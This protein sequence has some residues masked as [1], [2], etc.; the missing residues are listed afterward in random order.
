MLPRK[1]KA[2][3][4]VRVRD[5]YKHF[6]VSGNYYLRFQTNAKEMKLPIWVDVQNLDAP[7]PSLKSRLVV[8]ATR[9]PPSVDRRLY[10]QPP[11]H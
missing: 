10:N 6:P 4:E 8:K 9:L 1:F 11:R 5:V 3:K 7:V 2:L